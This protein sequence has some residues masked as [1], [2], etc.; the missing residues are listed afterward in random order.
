MRCILNFL[1]FIQYSGWDDDK[2]NDERWSFDIAEFT[3]SQDRLSSLA[4]LNTESDLNAK[5]NRT[6]PM[7]N[8]HFCYVVGSIPLAIVK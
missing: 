4:I 7:N 2:T 3:M 1:H 8:R 5:L 6:M